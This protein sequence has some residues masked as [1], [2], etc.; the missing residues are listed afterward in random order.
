MNAASRLS[1]KRKRNFFFL[2]ALQTNHSMVLDVTSVAG[3]QLREMTYPAWTASGI[4]PCEYLLTNMTPPNTFSGFSGL[5]EQFHLADLNWCWHSSMASLAPALTACKR[6]TVKA[7]NQ[8][9]RR[10]RVPLERR[11]LV[12]SK[13]MARTSI[14]PFLTSSTLYT[15]RTIWRCLKIFAIIRY[16]FENNFVGSSK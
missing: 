13:S 16:R 8:K 10:F 12:S 7:K 6:K 4:E 2:V 11:S 9:K 5:T 1:A 14:F 15:E 3:E